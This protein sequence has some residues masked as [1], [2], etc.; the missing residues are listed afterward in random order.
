MS[1]FMR[2]VRLWLATL[3]VG[4][5][6]VALPAPLAHADAA[7]HFQVTTDL[8]GD[9]TAGTAFNVT[10]NALDANDVLDASY[11]GTVHFSGGGDNASLPADTS[12]SG[13]TGTFPATLKQAAPQIITAED[14]GDDTINGNVHVDV[15]PDA[16][17]KLEI[18]GPSDAV[19]ARPSDPSTT[20]WVLSFQVD[21][22]D[23]W[24]NLETGNSDN[25]HA[26]L[27]TGGFSD[28]TTSQAASGGTASFGG[29]KVLDPGSYTIT[30]RDTDNAGVTDAT[31]N[32]FNI[33]PHAD[34][35][36][37]MSS[38]LT[39]VAG[40][41]QVYTVTVNNFGPNANGS[42]T[43]SGA[44]PTDTTLAGSTGG[45]CAVVSSQVECTRSG[46]IIDG[47]SDSFQITLG[48]PTNYA[49]GVATRSLAF[50][51]ALSSTTPTQDPQDT[52]PNGATDTSQIHAEADLGI[53]VTFA[54][55][56]PT[57]YSGHDAVAGT[58]EVF[59]MTTS[60]P[61]GPSD[62]TGFTATLT[63]PAYDG[64]QLTLVSAPGCVGSAAS[65]TVTCTSSST[66][67]PGN[68]QTFDATFAIVSSYT[69]PNST[70]ALAY[71]AA[72]SALTPSN[73]GSN[74]LADSTGNLSLNV[75][76]V[77]DV[78]VTQ[79]AA[80]QNATSFNALNPG[81]LNSA[82]YTVTVSNG[83]PSSAQNV[84]L[85]ETLPAT[86][87]TAAIKSCLG[88]G[89][90]PTTPYANGS[91]ISLNTLAIGGSAVVR[92]QAPL[93][94]SLR[95][96][97]ALSFP[98]GNATAVA[99]TSATDPAPGNNT[100]NLSFDLYTVPDA[101]T[102]GQVQPG[103]QKIGVVWTDPATGGNAITSY[104][105]IANGTAY[106]VPV[107]NTISLGGGQRSA[108]IPLSPTLLTNGTTYSVTIEARNGAG[109][110]SPSGSA[111]ATPCASCVITQL[112]TSRTLLLSS[113]GV[114][115]V[116]T[117]P[118]IT[119]NG[120]FPASQ[121][122]TAPGATTSDPKVSCLDIPAGV[123][124]SKVGDLVALRDETSVSGDC[125]LAGHPCLN[126]QSVVAIPPGT[127][128]SVALKS[129]IILDRTISTQ[130]Y[131]APCTKAP[132]GKYVYVVY[133]RQS[134]T[135]P[136]IPIGST[137]PTQTTVNGTVFPAW[138]PTVSGQ[139]VIPSGK[140]GCVVSY[141]PVNPSSTSP[142]TSSNG[143]EGNGDLR[144]TVL[145]YGDPRLHP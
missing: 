86:L 137:V 120:C 111:Q 102:M 118:A 126:G 116:I 3:V 20:A 115:Q 131:G 57:T 65:H 18:T 15:D 19:S 88:T 28:G 9:A 143:K 21:V 113:N 78:S 91:S 1:R 107:G 112:T 34:L 92:F 23:Q 119:A 71:S 46:G 47:G 130:I 17:F 106:N 83:G 29:L 90:T 75:D 121:S 56:G 124:N 22:K 145:F 44:L 100:H 114:D 26:T 61:S 32:T 49:N 48:V 138:C 39:G 80:E 98:T 53:G 35:Q 82:I 132:C 13:G 51:E 109:D 31:S 52:N 142:V 95:R 41:N 7:T 4:A 122:T 73:E 105:F 64:S 27:N 55:A 63:V 101:P 68:S 5:G 140:L 33:L 96:G 43:V 141:V 45:S 25:I 2:S 59:H 97:N 89:C 87:Q 38:A 129:T 67:T 10:V 16:P 40:T 58:N 50:T 69:N 135:T 42:Y 66:M 72:L 117:N 11:A 125:P 85:T 94:Q 6:V 62:N 81:N 133:L 12:L 134:T 30:V 37:T 60:N 103:D 74:T 144:L 76:S 128:T 54:Q 127:G 93:V 110:S 99:A 108:T 8:T 136:S 84:T 70:K 139:P 79:T 36:L 14:Q 123:A 104:D 77:A 24:G